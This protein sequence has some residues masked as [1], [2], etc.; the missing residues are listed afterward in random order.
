MY[1]IKYLNKQY[2]IYYYETMGIIYVT[3]KYDASF[4]TKLSLTTDDHSI[5]YIMLAKNAL[6]INNFRMLFHKG[7]FR[8]KNLECKQMVIQ[9]LSY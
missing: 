6:I 5:N 8:F 1:T 3:Y 9:M 4:P 2:S 7:C